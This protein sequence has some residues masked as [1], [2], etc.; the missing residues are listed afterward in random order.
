MSK[1][2]VG[3]Q[4]TGTAIPQ[5]DAKAVRKGAENRAREVA[6]GEAAKRPPRRTETMFI[7]A[8]PVPEK[9]DIYMGNITIR[10]SRNEGTGHCI[11]RVPNELVERFMRH[12]L[13]KFGHIILAE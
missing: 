13:V 10:G 7:T 3:T 4:T 9:F 2:V 12:S 8:G 1:A 11:F 5:E 6:R